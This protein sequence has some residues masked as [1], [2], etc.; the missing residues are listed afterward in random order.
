MVGT[1]TVS[2]GLD[3]AES[4]AGGTVAGTAASVAAGTEAAAVSTVT[5]D[6]VAAGST[7]GQAS[8]I[9]AENTV[10]A[11]RIEAATERTVGLVVG[12]RHTGAG[13]TEQRT[14]AAEAR[15]R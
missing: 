4:A 1:G 8:H 15:R 12:R 3:T 6:T 10:V 13:H 14:V 2:A 11:E 5:G 9:V 7:A